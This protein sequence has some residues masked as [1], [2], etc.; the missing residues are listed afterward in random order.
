[1]NLTRLNFTEM[2]H[3]NFDIKIGFYMFNESIR[4]VVF[5]GIVMRFQGNK[6]VWDM[7]LDAI[8]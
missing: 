3:N 7:R 1:M 6:I 4:D 8:K 2:T 5:G